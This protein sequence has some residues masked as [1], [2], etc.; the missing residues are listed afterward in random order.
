MVERR[1]LLPRQFADWPGLL[2]IEG[3][4]EP[5]WRNC[6]VVDVSTTGAGV[7]LQQ[8]PSIDIIGRNVLLAIHLRAEVRHHS[9]PTETGMRLGLQFVNLSNG[10]RDYIRSLETIGAVW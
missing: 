9:S 3:C 7:E 8:S 10:E 4:S 1:R 6:R 2:A 5:R